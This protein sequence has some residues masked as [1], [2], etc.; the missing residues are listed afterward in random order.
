MPTLLVVDD[1]PSVLYSF[2]RVLEDDG[3]SVLTASTATE[4]LAVARERRPAVVVLD[5]QLPDGN[6][7]DVLTQLRTLGH[8]MPVLVITAHGTAELAIEAMKR[9]AFD[10]LLKPV[11]FR[12]V[13]RLVARALEASRLMQAPAV[14][15]PDEPS[16]RIVGRSPAI[17]EVC[18]QIGRLA[19]QDVTVLIAGESGV[20]KELVARALYQHSRRAD[21][22]FLAINCAAIPETLLESELFG[23]EAGAFTGATK[24]R[25]GRFEQCDGGTLFLDEVGE[26]ALPLQAKMLR[27]LQEQR[28]ERVGGSRPVE[29]DV[30]VLAAT[31][32]DLPALAAAGKFRK[33]LYYRLAGLTVTVPPLRERAGDVS[34]LAHHFL[35]RSAAEAGRDVRGFDPDALALLE[36]HDWPGNVREL[37]NAIR[38][39]VLHSSGQL[40]LVE[41][42]PLSVRDRPEQTAGAAEAA[43]GD[44]EELVESMLHDGAGDLHARV[45]RAAE[46][47]LFARVLRHT[48]GHQ[49][50]A[51]ELLGLNRST[52]R[53]K[54]RELGLSV[55]R[56]LTEG[57]SAGEADG[58]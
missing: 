57:P 23:H 58:G 17:H 49:S 3:L 20:G 14:P 31:N 27:V 44:L 6:G 54:L 46:R 18:K 32:Q 47:V 19:P 28:F 48:K 15:P 53:Y 52:L 36:R 10:Y 2:R 38:H 12:Q 43:G 1:E 13:S 22:P 55:D 39:A 16:E 7:L 45:V 42:L 25:V 51:S 41:H 56:V 29:T 21:K 9:G 40:V 35:F 37:Q 50:R 33:D 11:D 26:L 5:C 4:G 30:R 24:Q 8:R 34:E